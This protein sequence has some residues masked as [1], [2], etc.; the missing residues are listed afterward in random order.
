MFQ[1]IGCFPVHLKQQFISVPLILVIK[2][3][4]N[5]VFALFL[6]VTLSLVYCLWRE[7]VEVTPRPPQLPATRVI[8]FISVFGGKVWDSQCSA[9]FLVS[10][11][12]VF[13][14]SLWC[15]LLILPACCSLLLLHLYQQFKTILCVSLSV[16]DYL[17]NHEIYEYKVQIRLVYSW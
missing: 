1:Q 3:V 13:L 5:T 12:P 8:V 16:L 11:T 15:Y 9:A 7:S 14:Y 10:T 6:W 4:F 17:H 2:Q